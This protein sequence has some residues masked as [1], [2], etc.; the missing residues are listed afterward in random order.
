MPSSR[1]CRQTQYSSGLHRKQHGDPIAKEG[2]YVVSSP[3]SRRSGAANPRIWTPYHATTIHSAFYLEVKPSDA[4]HF[5][6][7]RIFLPRQGSVRPAMA[8]GALSAVDRYGRAAADADHRRGHGPGAGRHGPLDHA[9]RRHVAHGVAAA[10][11]TGG[12]P[13]R[14]RDGMIVLDRRS[15]AQ[16]GV[17]RSPSAM[18][19]EPVL[20]RAVVRGIV[21][22]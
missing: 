11:G 4:N 6:A 8:G 3:F 10:G 18:G 19:G 15:R 5:Q 9:V 2:E 7:F 13:V 20:K 21:A 12:N 22:A 16:P 14:L 1:S 17:S